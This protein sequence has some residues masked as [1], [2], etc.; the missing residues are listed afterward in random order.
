M[1]IANK[2]HRSTAGFSLVEFMLA[3]SI[4][5]MMMGGVIYSHIMG[6]NLHQWSMSKVGANDQSREALG[7]LQ[8]EIRSAKRIQIGDYATQGFQTPALGRSQIGQTLRIFPTTNDN[9]YVQYRLA[10]IGQQF[11]LRRTKVN[12]NGILSA[13]AVA[14]HLTNNPALFGLEDFRGNTLTEPSATTVVRVTLD[15]K[16]F[17]YPITQVGSE[18]YY[19]HY[20]LQTR[21][22]KRANE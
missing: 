13:R 12:E 4:T 7:H 16:Q 19:D 10:N 22:A 21:I 6:Q 9:L 17:Q 2:H 8:D 1:K 5:L 3:T 14:K 18:Y 11:E 20:R 15:F